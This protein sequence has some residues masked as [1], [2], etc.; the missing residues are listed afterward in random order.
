MSRGKS[1]FVEMKGF[2]SDFSAESDGFV[3][4]S[5]PMVVKELSDDIEVKALRHV[6]IDAA[7][8]ALIGGGIGAAGGY[9]TGG[10]EGAK[11]GAI[12]GAALGGVGTAALG[13][14]MRSRSRSNRAAFDA[15]TTRAAKTEAIKAERRNMGQTAG[16]AFLGGFGTG[17]VGRREGQRAA[18]EQKDFSSG[19]EVKESIALQFGKRQVKGKIRRDMKAEGKQALNDGFDEAIQKG[20]VFKELSDEIEVKALPG[21]ARAMLYLGRPGVEA[22]DAVKAGSKINSDLAR[23]IAA[24]RTK[25]R[26]LDLEMSKLD[27]KIRGLKSYEGLVCKEL[28]DEIEV[29][30]SGEEHFAARA[31]QGGSL[32]DPKGRITSKPKVSDVQEEGYKERGKRRRKLMQERG[33]RV[34]GAPKTTSFQNTANDA[35][36][37]A[38]QEK[39]KNRKFSISEEAPKTE[40]PKGKTQNL[41]TTQVGEPK[42]KPAAPKPA[43][44]KAVEAAS[45]GALRKYGKYGAAALGVGALGYGAYRLLKRK[46]KG[47]RVR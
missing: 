31:A 14:V 24:N 1:E 25:G 5:E 34:W 17:L 40:V 23:R 38:F 3:Q 27:A 7:T 28:S 20:F 26:S 30:I 32:R 43:P 18:K 47:F 2:L 45:P 12:H 33:E 15:A 37:A 6:A 39:L 46:E 16:A 4:D 19:I 8:G 10:S 21:R 11:R 13:G 22:L 36:Q 29:K 42:M 9:S 44:A 35:S 41:P